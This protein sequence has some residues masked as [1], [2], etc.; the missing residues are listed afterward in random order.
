MSRPSVC[1]YTAMFDGYDRILDHVPQTVDCHFTVFTD[2][3]SEIA[4]RRMD[5]VRQEPAGRRSPVLRNVWLRLFPFDIPELA[6][7]QILIYL[8]ANVRIRDASFVERV[9]Q[10]HEAAPDF[11][12]LLSEHPF[13]NCLYEE[14]RVSEG[15]A[16]YRNTDLARQVAA[17]R[18]AGFPANA[19]LYWNGFM[20]FNRGSDQ[21]RVRR[22]QQSYWTEM[23][24]YNLTD[25]GHP[26]GQVS[27]PYCL[28]QCPLKLITVPQLYQS[29]TLE[30]RPHLR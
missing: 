4:A 19:G 12:L 21:P 16:K 28:W 2:A 27:L 10:H 11:D 1:V 25:D 7:H 17:Y 20:V 24:A 15:M 13:R 5:V 30:L 29:A 14:A 23:I 18:R 6:E 9:L 8:D 22:F 26:Q 3:T